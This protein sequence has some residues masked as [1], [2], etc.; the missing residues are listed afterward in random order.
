M[1]VCAVR[2]LEIFMT[3]HTSDLSHLYTLYFYGWNLSMSTGKVNIRVAGDTRIINGQNDKTL[4][5][6][7]LEVMT[8]SDE[9]QL[10]VSS[11]TECIQSAL[12]QCTGNIRPCP[13]R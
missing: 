10:M 5:H 1:A 8:H 6:G 2:V 12:M 13:Q 7:V 3:V 4:V 11:E 9:S